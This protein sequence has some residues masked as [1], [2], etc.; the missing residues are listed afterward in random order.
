[1]EFQEKYGKFMSRV[2]GDPELRARVFAA[3]TDVLKEQGLDIPREVEI[4]VV[5][6]S[7]EVWHVILP[8]SPN[9]ALADASME[10]VAG[11]TPHGDRLPV[12]YVL[13]LRDK[14]NSES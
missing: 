2:Q 3:P 11:G 1:M 9:A 13:H 8:P 14:L 5:E 12:G 7:A 6:D 4:R 10:A